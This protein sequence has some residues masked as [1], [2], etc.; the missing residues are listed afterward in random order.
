[1]AT[2]VTVARINVKVS[3]D[4]KQFR[5]KLKA[6]LEAIERTLKGNIEV[7]AHLDSA[8]A[9]ADFQRMKSMMEREGRIKVGVD[10][11]P[12]SK[13]GK[14][15]GSEDGGG[16][17]GKGNTG[18]FGL[19]VKKKGLL[20][21]PSF[22]SGINASGYAIIFAAIT[23][24]AAPLFG[25]LTTALLTLP[26]LIALVLT[27]VAALALGIEGFK[28]AAASLAQPFQELKDIM[29][30]KVQEQFTPVFE[31][32][33]SV[34]PTLK[35]AMPDVT[36]GLANM[37]QGV[38]DAVTAPQNLAMIEETIR[39][40]GQSLGAAAPGMRDFT[41]GLIEL[42]RDFTV[43]ALPGLVEWFNGAGADF[44]EWVSGL[45]LKQAFSGLGDVLQRVLEMFGQMGKSGMDWIQDPSKVNDFT[46]GLDDLATALEDIVELSSNLNDI[47]KNLVPDFSPSGFW[48][49]ITDPLTSADA[50]WRKMF[51]MPKEP[52]NGSEGVGSGGGSW[53]AKAEV[54]GIRQ[55]L[56]KVPSAAQQ[57][58]QATELFTSG[59]ATTGTFN[60][61]PFA[62]QNTNQSAPI[63]APAEPPKLPVPDDTEAR[64]KLAEY[65]KLVDDAANKV[66][67]SMA[68]AAGQGQKVPP[69]DL[70]AFKQA[71][72][73]L[74]NA[75]AQAMQG[76][77]AALNGG[78]QAILGIVTSWAPM[79]T[80]ALA[81]MNAIGQAAG[82]QLAAGMAAGIAAGQSYVISAAV[83]MAMAAKAGAES[84]LGIK[85]PS[86]VFMKIGDQTG[87]GMAIGMEK[88]FGPV[89]DQ[90][91]DLSGKIAA[92]FDKGDDPTG[93]LNGYTDK[94]A[95]RMEKVLGF[96]SKIL[97]RQ[98]RD[99]D[100][101]AKASGDTSFTAKADAIRAQID[102]L[103]YQK[104]SLDLA[105]EY[106][107]L[108][109]GGESDWKGPIAK[110]LHSMSMMPGEFMGNV[111][112]QF[113]GDLGISGGGL[114]G[115]LTDYGNQLGNSFVF[116]VGNM[117]DALTAH[118]NLMNRQSL[119]VVGK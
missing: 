44:K 18:I 63:Q 12:G 15:P 106:A 64:A 81:S 54:D 61:D 88:G 8:Q 102:D 49:D 104:E 98:A 40:I 96:H 113:M 108:Q 30:S 118:N 116:N 65:D 119:G 112:Q 36:Q 94:E 76:V 71:W 47:F 66:K 87:Q 34:F 73:E 72:A 117:E 97:T 75:V 13:P 62:T 21:N 22:G 5:E 17:G 110:A 114:M 29:S 85:S 14:P 83:G 41:S 82:M 10:Y 38:T 55:S 95:S 43:D 69:P 56:E 90:A 48:K 4:T 2:G 23:A 92:A 6:E 32:L 103:A 57:A 16:S 67:E 78:T 68:Q 39:G 45:D 79:I 70:S 50:P 46:D 11:V 24:L 115:A 9:R 52:G 86:R 26:G 31:S 1:M 25:L 59:S 37:M 101:Q 99:L 28:N 107:E 80:A 60:T 77:I 89:L 74:P 33:R 111:G 7:K 3:P 84:A 35:S 58:Q 20:A 105:Q 100:K 109:G 27:P 42:A 19:G 53:G 51:N 93:F 91:K